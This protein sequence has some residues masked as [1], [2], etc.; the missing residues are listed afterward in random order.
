LLS[1]ADGLDFDK[2]EMDMEAE[3]RSAAGPVYWMFAHSVPV[4]TLAVPSSLAWHL[5]SF[6]HL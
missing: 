6:Q 1:F 5:V 2:F 3:D 4:H